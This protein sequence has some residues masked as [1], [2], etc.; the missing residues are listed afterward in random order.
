MWSVLSLMDL[1]KC[2][3]AITP[4]DVLCCVCAQVAWCHQGSQLCLRLGLRDGDTLNPFG[5]ISHFKLNLTS[6]LTTPN[7][8]TTWP[9]SLF[10][11]KEWFH[12][13]HKSLTALGTGGG[14]TSPTP[15]FSACDL[16]NPK[17]L[18]MACSA[19]ECLRLVPPQ[20]KQNTKWKFEPLS[21]KS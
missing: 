18:Q 11:N 12:C 20:W 15:E 9:I 3:H 13:T 6:V 10:W 4:R 1:L 14:G 21:S 7:S 5:L 16:L 19:M 2:T 17:A 8:H